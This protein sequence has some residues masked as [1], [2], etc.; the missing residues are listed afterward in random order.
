VAIK[1]IQDSLSAIKIFQL[2]TM[3]IFFLIEHHKVKVGEENFL[4]PLAAF[5]SKKFLF[6]IEFD[7][8]IVNM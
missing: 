1:K 7:N 3:F 6:T 8:L 5:F 2:I 4:L